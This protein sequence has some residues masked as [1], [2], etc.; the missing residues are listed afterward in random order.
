MRIVNEVWT[1]AEDALFIGDN[2]A[3]RRQACSIA[4]FSAS[5]REQWVIVIDHRESIDSEQPRR[6]NAIHSVSPQG[7]WT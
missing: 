5:S 6:V 4:Y 2:G 3:G 1:N 7:F